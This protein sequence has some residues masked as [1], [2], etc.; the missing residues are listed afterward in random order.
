MGRIHFN[1][2]KEERVDLIENLSFKQIFEGGEELVMQVSEQRK[3]L[4]QGPQ[5]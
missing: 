4:G 1:I 2:G 3:Q 5:G